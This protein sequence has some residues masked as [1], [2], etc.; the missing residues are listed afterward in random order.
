MHN[1][2]LVASQ[3][4]KELIAQY[5]VNSLLIQKI[6][7]HSG[8]KV[9]LLPLHE[10][11]SAEAHEGTTIF[12]TSSG[13]KHSSS[14]QLSDFEFIFDDF[15]SL[16]RISKSTFINTAYIESY[17]KG[18]T[19]IVF[20]KNGSEFEVSRRKKSEILALLSNHKM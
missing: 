5:D 20:M 13:A 17:S 19:C 16:I 2:K 15:P 10:I 3:A 6:A 18:S 9:L 11:L 14:K 1:N 4:I 12:T 7:V 8:N